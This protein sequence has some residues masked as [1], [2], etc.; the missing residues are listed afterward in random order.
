LSQGEVQPLGGDFKAVTS[1]RA[2]IENAVNTEATSAASNR[3]TAF[4]NSRRQRTAQN[5]GAASRLDP[6]VLI[7]ADE[8]L[9]LQ[10]LMP[11]V[12]GRAPA[13]PLG[14]GSTDIAALKPLK[15]IVVA[16]PMELPPLA[17]T[18]PQ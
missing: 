5:G 4:P 2:S 18:P 3:N 1:G 8:A 14:D 10:R 7:A 9:A 11:G 17:I 12:Q 15:E 13:I 16:P 6:E